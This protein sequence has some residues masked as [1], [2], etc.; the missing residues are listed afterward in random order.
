MLKKGLSTSYREN[1]SRTN[2]R[3]PFNIDKLLKS[4]NNVLTFMHAWLH[5]MSGRST[6]SQ[7]H[8]S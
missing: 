2:K 1:I 6:H 3:Q 7:H 4:V 5:A 8:F